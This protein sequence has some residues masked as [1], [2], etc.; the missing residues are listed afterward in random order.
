M[1]QKTKRIWAI[2]ALVFICIFTVMFILFL[3]G[4]GTLGTAAF[5]T[6][7][8][9]MLVALAIGGSISCFI[10][11]LN[12][13][14][15]K[16]HRERTEREKELREMKEAEEKEAAEKQGQEELDKNQPE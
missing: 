5:Q 10:L 4:E 13:R 2:I 11:V 6:V 16:V 1:E 15:L 12:N 9:I 3:F 8:I 7:F 14:D